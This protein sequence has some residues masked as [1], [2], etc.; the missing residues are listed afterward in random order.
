M[1]VFQG[2]IVTLRRGRFNRVSEQPRE[3]KSRIVAQAETAPR[4]NRAE[5]KIVERRNS[6]ERYEHRPKGQVPGLDFGAVEWIQ[7]TTVLLPPAPQAGASA[8]PDFVVKILVL[9]T[10]VRP[11]LRKCL[12]SAAR[13]ECAKITPLQERCSTTSIAE[14]HSERAK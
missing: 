9:E 6:C 11:P 5:C 14:N 10:Y 12:D 7:T 13:R 4:L 3:A 1:G 8:N 2:V